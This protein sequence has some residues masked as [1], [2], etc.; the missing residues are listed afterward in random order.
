MRPANTR[1]IVRCFGALSGFGACKG[2]EKVIRVSD[3]IQ[4]S[5]KSFSAF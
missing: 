5:S 1:V 4:V 3:F 2:L